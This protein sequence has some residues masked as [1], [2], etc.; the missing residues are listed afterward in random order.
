[1]NSISNLTTNL[2]SN[3]VSKQKLAKV[4]VKSSYNLRKF[5]DNSFLFALKAIYPKLPV[6]KFIDKFKKLELANKIRDV[7]IILTDKQVGYLEYKGT[8]FNS[9]QRLSETVS[10]K[11]ILA[12]VLDS[13]EY[14]FVA[15]DDGLFTPNL[16]D[17]IENIRHHRRNVSFYELNPNHKDWNL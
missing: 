14:H 12:F 13:G 8:Y 3:K 2:N 17:E 16:K 11:N 5:E 1:M 7:N 15:I 9:L 10:T 6:R 4:K